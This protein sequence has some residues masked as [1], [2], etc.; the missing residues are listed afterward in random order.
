MGSDY[1]FVSLRG[2]V[3]FPPLVYMLGIVDL[4]G[5]P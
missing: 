2:G 5:S 4:S 3:R 1:D